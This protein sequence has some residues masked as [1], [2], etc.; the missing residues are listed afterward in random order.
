MDIQFRLEAEHDLDRL[1]SHYPD[2]LHEILASWKEIRSKLLS[3]AL[4]EESEGWPSDLDIS[5]RKYQPRQNDFLTVY[6]QILPNEKIIVVLGFAPTYPHH[7]DHAA[8]S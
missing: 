8:E 7:D 3:S 5:F 1:E 6:Y 4:D 2:R